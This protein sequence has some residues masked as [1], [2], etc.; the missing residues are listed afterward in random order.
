[1]AAVEDGL[2]ARALA[3]QDVTTATLH[4]AVVALVREASGGGSATA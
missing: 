3:A 2:G 4:P 1:V